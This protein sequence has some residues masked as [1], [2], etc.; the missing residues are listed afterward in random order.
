MTCGSRAVY[1]FFVDSLARR[2][3]R[4]SHLSLVRHCSAAA[5]GVPLDAGAPSPLPEEPRI[6]SPNV[7]RLVDEIVGLSL[8]EVSDLNYALKKRLNLP[9]TPVMSAGMFVGSAA[10]APMPS[11][12]DGSAEGEATTPDVPQKMTFSLKLTK[13]DD[14]KKIALIKEIRNVVPGL[15]LVQAKKF[16]DSV[17]AVVKEDMGKQ[18]AEELKALLE[19]A[20]GICEIA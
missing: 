16:V 19:K 6:I 15:N 11:T 9:D 10:T 2:L 8:L 3:T 18:E 5:G 13:F 20:G 7:K 12:T 17:P 1:K 4:T 14:A